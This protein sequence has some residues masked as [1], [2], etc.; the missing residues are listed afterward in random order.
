MGK[1][2]LATVGVACT[3]ALLVSACGSNG[4]SGSGS[5]SGGS[6]TLDIGVLTSLSGP[7]SSASAS[8]VDGV[9]ARFQAYEADGGKCADAVDFNIVK[10]DDQS[11]PQGAL[12]ALQKLVQQDKVYSVIE[13]SGLFFGASQWA[14]TQGA[15]TPL[16]GGAFDGAPEWQKYPDT[17]NLFPNFP[18]VDQKKVFS[19]MGDYL[20]STGATKVAGV[21]YNSPSS[22]AGLENALT[23]ADS[24]GLKRGYVNNS[25]AFGSTDVSAIVLGIMD[26]GADSVI[27][28]INPDT[29]FAVIGGLRQANYPMKAIVSAAG[30]GGDLLQSPPAVQAAQGVTFTTV[31][32][33]VEQQTDATKYLSDS[34]K[35]YG[36]TPSGVPGFFGTMGWYGADVLIHGLEKAGCDASQEDFQTTLR[37]DHSWDGGGMYPSEIPFDSTKYDASCGYFVKM[38]GEG[39]VPVEKFVPKC[40]ESVTG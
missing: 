16:I 6:K 25:V 11:T 36:N 1:R 13:E 12:S 10:G 14:A 20:K 21:A 15:G 23:S 22:Q 31:W 18:V 19:T 4:D 24:V 40:G 35:K 17:K 29:A 32:A 9:T 2:G 26:S 8:T 39:F 7:A 3:V 27:L 34:M 30:Y 33:P 5:S 38:Q 37:K 28:T